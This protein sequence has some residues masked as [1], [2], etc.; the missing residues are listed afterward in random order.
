MFHC[1]GNRKGSP[2]HVELIR[3][4]ARE[5]LRL[6]ERRAIVAALGAAAA[7]AIAGVAGG[8]WLVLS[9]TVASPVHGRRGLRP[10][11]CGRGWRR[12]RRSGRGNRRRGGDLALSTKRRNRGGCSPWRF[13]HRPRR[14]LGRALDAGRLVR[15]SG[16]PHWRPAGGFGDRRSGGAGLRGEHP[17]SERRR[18]GHSNRLRALPD[19]AH[20]GRL[21]GGRRVGLV[22]HRS[23]DWWAAWSTRSLSYQAAHK[24]R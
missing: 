10:P 13:R 19:V 14:P 6:A 11:R 21:C 3:L 2:P 1:S 12:G 23:S 18:H 22:A 5:A 9:P 8:L 17:A 20:G 7:G 24:S 15:L 16:E 4:R